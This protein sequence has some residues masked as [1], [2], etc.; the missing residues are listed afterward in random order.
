[1]QKRP[2]ARTRSIARIRPSA[3]P[4]QLVRLPRQRRSLAR[5]QRARRAARPRRRARLG[6]REPRRPAHERRRRGE[7]TAR[8]DVMVRH[9]ATREATV[10]EGGTREPR[11]PGGA[12]ARAGSEAVSGGRSASAR[13]IGVASVTREQGRESRVGAQRSALAQTSKAAARCEAIKSARTAAA[14]IRVAWRRLRIGLK[15]G[16]RQRKGIQSGVSSRASRGKRSRGAIDCP[17]LASTR[18]QQT[19]ARRSHSVKHYAAV[20]I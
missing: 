13:P 5:V 14:A 15:S 1:M 18:T 3:R 11:A 20:H 2:R 19:A 17:A 12:Q 7:Q 6:C 4:S 9:A 10:G 16:W 8:A